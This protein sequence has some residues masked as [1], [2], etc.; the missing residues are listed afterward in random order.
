MN[1]N[2]QYDSKDQLSWTV[3]NQMPAIIIAALQTKRV[4]QYICYK[5]FV[6]SPALNL[7]EKFPNLHNLNKFQFNEIWLK[8]F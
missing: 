8:T 6:R 1:K 4:F 5:I 2:Y 7:L 3:Q